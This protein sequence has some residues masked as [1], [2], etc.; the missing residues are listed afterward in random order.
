MYFTGPF[1]TCKDGSSSISCNNNK[2]LKDKNNLVRASCYMPPSWVRT[3]PNYENDS[4]NDSINAME[5]LHS[6]SELSTDNQYN[7]WVPE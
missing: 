4:S 2:N 7:S 6:M 1:I 5:Q 3:N